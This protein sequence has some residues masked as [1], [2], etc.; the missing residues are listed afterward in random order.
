MGGRGGSVWGMALCVLPSPWDPGAVCWVF[1]GARGR[2]AGGSQSWT[3]G[4]VP[5]GLIGTRARVPGWW[6]LLLRKERGFCCEVG[7]KEAGGR[8][9]PA[10]RSRVPA[11]FRGFST[12]PSGQRSLGGGGGWGGAGKGS[13]AFPCAV[14]P[15]SEPGFRASSETGQDQPKPALR[16]QAPGE[17]P[18][19][20]G[21]PGPV[22]TTLQRCYSAEPTPDGCSGV[23][24]SSSVH[25]RHCES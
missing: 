24:V 12:T 19:A 8:W 23:F 21:P 11:R 16:L 22:T 10:P 15:G 4:A 7:S 20:S 2:W 3:P 14:C 5:S 25:R 1:P 17:A 13:Q 6:R 18:E 9:H